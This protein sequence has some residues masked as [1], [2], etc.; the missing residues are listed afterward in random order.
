[1]KT[2]ILAMAGAALALSSVATTA[3]AQEA[4]DPDLRCAAWAMIAGAQQKDPAKQ[5]GLGFMMSYFMGR[6]EARTGMKVEDKITPE[7]MPSVIGDVET[8]NTAC[9]ARAED[10]GQRLEA[11]LSH[12]RP[13]AKGNTNAGASR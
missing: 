11:T 1:M 13:P 7:T 12:M 5:R 2:R 4:A 3:Q 8:A 6:Y 9:A 10:F